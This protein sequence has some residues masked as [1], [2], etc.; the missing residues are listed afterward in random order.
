[1][2]REPQGQR[3]VHERPVHDKNK[4]RCNRGLAPACMSNMVH[5][6]VVLHRSVTFRAFR[7]AGASGKRSL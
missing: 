7:A 6:R 3:P 4:G 1:M 2:R 5:D